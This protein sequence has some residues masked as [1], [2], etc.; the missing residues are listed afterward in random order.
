VS[1]VIAALV[2][3][4]MLCVGL[5]LGG[6][7][8]SLPQPVRDVFVDD[9]TSL[10][11]QARDVIKDN[12]TRKVPNGQLDDASLREAYA[13]AWVT[14]L[15]STAESFGMT[16]VESLASGTPAVVLRGGGGPTEIVT[17][18]TGLL[19]DPEHLPGALG[20]ALELSRQA[21][22][23]AAC[24]DRARDFDWDAAVVPALLAVYAG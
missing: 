5:Y 18:G 19:A 14:V 7:P 23:V 1:K 8:E 3:V 9:S 17:P 13:R 10:Q 15:P 24:R 4:A 22:T 16:V 21:G 6:H 2:A 12:F 11:A 20:E